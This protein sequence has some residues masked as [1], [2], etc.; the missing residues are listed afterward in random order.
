MS[1]SESEP[2]D[3]A[4][5]RV[6]KT[7]IGAAVTSLSLAPFAQ[8]NA[9]AILKGA[10]DFRSISLVNNRTGEWLQTVYWV[11]GEY[12][13]DA[14]AAVNKIMRDWRQEKVVEID[15]RTIDIISAAHNLLEC[16]E[17]F[18][19]VSGYRSPQTNAMLRK[20]SRGVARNSYHMKGMACDL[21]LKTRSIRQIALAG[22]SLGAGGV[23]T[24]SR[25]EFVHLDSGPVRDWGR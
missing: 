8:A 14:L 17:P 24:Y 2:L 15:R 9:P 25:S 7:A 4:R 13:P 22:K 18:E 6:L 19:V 10:G 1:K 16:G 23:G 3:P 20:R 5:R 21:T 12:I 11:E